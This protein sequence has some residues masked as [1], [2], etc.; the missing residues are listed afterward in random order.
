MSLPPHNVRIIDVRF[1]LTCMYN[2]LKCQFNRIL[3]PNMIFFHWI[4][5]MDYLTTFCEI[6]MPILIPKSLWHSR[7]EA[8]NGFKYF[9]SV[10]TCN[11]SEWLSTTAK[12][13][14][15]QSL[16]LDIKCCKVESRSYKTITESILR[17]ASG[18]WRMPEK[19]EMAS[20]ITE[21]KIRRIYGPVHELHSG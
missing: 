15:Q 8:V 21:R 16:F 19:V 6:S 17:Y 5:T 13:S 11:I 9:G 1:S 14:S 10:L 3:L 4:L 20:G 18:I 7:F 2:Y 12:Y